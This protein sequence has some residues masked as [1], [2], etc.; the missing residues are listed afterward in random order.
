M[1]LQ[2]IHESGHL[3][4]G[5]VAPDLGTSLKAGGLV[6]VG[7]LDDVEP[8]S[9]ITATALMRMKGSSS[10]ARTTV[11]VMAGLCRD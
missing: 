3:D 9:S 7:G 4:V 1:R 2:A 8:A 5:E 10:T 6:G 11:I